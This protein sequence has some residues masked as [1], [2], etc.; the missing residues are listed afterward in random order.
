MNFN[1]VV[2]ARDSLSSNVVRNLIGDRVIDL[3]GDLV[4][5]D[6]Q[7]SFLGKVFNFGKKLVGFLVKSG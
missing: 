2:L 3:A 6:D 1:T 7:G 4:A 5:G